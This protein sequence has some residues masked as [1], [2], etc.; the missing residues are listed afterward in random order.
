MNNELNRLNDKRKA[1]KTIDLGDYDADMSGIKIHIYAP[2]AGPMENMKSFIASN[3]SA[4][5][6]NMSS[7]QVIEYLNIEAGL[8]ISC[9]TLEMDADISKLTHDEVKAI[10]YNAYQEIVNIIMEL[11]DIPLPNSHS[12]EAQTK[13]TE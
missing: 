2:T 4:T 5:K 11:A 12:L 10:P 6:G 9:T 13:S 8:I 3:P 1:K 7:E